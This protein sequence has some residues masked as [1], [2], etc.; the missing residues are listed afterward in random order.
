MTWNLFEWGQNSILSGAFKGW[1][2]RASVEMAEAKCCTRT[3]YRPR[4]WH[5]IIWG[6][7]LVAS[8]LKELSL[9]SVS[10]SL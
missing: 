2:V 9:C 10:Y 3:Y 7:S 1:A 5:C 8:T 4:G 6:D